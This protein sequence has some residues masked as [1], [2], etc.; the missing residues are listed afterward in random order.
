MGIDIGG[1]GIKGALV[2]LS[3]GELL[4]RRVRISTPQPSPPK[5]V[6]A[7]VRELVERINADTPVPADAPAGCGLPCVIKD[8]LVLTAAN[9]DKDWI[10]ESADD[11]VGKAAGRRV[12]ALNDAD[13]AG[14]AEM[15]LGAGRDCNG[16]VLVLTIGRGIGSALFV[17]HRLVPNTEFGHIELA[18]KDAETRVSAVARERRK[19]RWKGWATEFNEYLKRLEAYVWPDLIILGGGVS[20]VMPKYRDYL[21]SRA[22]IV[23]AQHL[24]TA[25][26][27]GAAIYASERPLAERPA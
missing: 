17:D 16:T 13:A 2:E 7:T 15:R 22:P 11:V 12:Y 23:A 24:N 19:V 6:A 21:K 18:G 9:I 14:I 26:I 1:S 8:G 20:K 5:A 27:I 3:T 4:S 10:G 25:G